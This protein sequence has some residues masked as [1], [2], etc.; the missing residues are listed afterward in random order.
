MIDFVRK[1]GGV[2]IE[3]KGAT[4]YAVATCVCHICSCIFGDMQTALPVSTMHHGEYGIDDVCISTLAVIDDTGVS[5]KVILPLT[6]DEI[7]KLQASAA[8][9][10]EVI[11]SITI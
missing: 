7:A 3:R 6:E 10:K 8:K 2:I 5:G 1:S 9:L 4:F 11:G